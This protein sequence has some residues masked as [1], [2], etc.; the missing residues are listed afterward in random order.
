MPSVKKEIA[1]STKCLF[2]N[3][4]HFICRGI[5]CQKRKR[6]Q[7]NRGK[8]CVIMTRRNHSG[9][10]KDLIYLGQ[11]GLD[12]L[13]QEGLLD[14]VVG[15]AGGGGGGGSGGSGGCG[16]GG[17]LPLLPEHDKKLWQ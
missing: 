10:K 13:A 4:I 6:R 8:K 17:N 16:G 11:A 5:H 9:E 3:E 7:K 15:G 1:T 12:S 14:A 2:A